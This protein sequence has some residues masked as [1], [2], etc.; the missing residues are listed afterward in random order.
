MTGS[1]KKAIDETKR[2]RSIQE[3]Y[4][5]VNNITPSSIKKEIRDI[6]EREYHDDAGYAD[7]VADYKTKYRSNNAGELSELIATIRADMLE[8]ADTLQFEKAA[9]LRDQMQEIEKKLELIRK[10]R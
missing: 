3:E 10:T 6:I 4:N 7:Y 8:A 9:L 5:R 2:R 1:M